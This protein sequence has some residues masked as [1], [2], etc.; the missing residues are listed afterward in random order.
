MTDA[1]K[2]PY[3][4]LT[5]D[6]VIAG[7][8]AQMGRATGAVMPLNSY[9]NRVYEVQME[10]EMEE[11]AEPL[12]AKF[13]RPGRWDK[14]TI[15]EEHQFTTELVAADV[16]VVP[17]L[18][19]NG[20]TL[21]EGHGYYYSLFPK[22]GGRAFEVRTEEDL[23][24][25]GRLIGRLHGVGARSRFRTRPQLNVSTAGD[26]NI[27]TILTSAQLPDDL[28]AP[29]K[30][31]LEHTLEACHT[32]WQHVNPATLRLHGD[33]HTGNVLVKQD[34]FMVDLDDCVTGPAV[35]DLWMLAAGQF[36]PPEREL[37]LVLEG[38]QT[39]REFDGKELR[40]VETLRTLRMVQ[41]TAWLARRWHDPTFPKNF[42]FFAEAMYWQNL[43]GNLREQL[44]LLTH[45]QE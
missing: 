20:E 9:E 8:E 22:R 17:P 6:V 13:Y 33:A 39:F 31:I 14:Q 18:A 36:A 4:D 45:P 15:L 12:I 38:Y 40:L 3:K 2:L 16:D 26:D 42:P 7:V 32:R 21:F 30:T 29:L 1:N 28:R 35:Q 11:G 25:L 27:Q 19:V 10:S 44:A 41:Y 37:E 34:P 24:Q 5:P 43:I 23:R